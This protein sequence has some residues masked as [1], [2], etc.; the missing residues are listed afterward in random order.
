MP[1]FVLLHHECPLD[2]DK[3]SHWDF[4]VEAEGVL[5]TWELRELPTPWLDALGELRSAP[6]QQVYATR[7]ADHRMAFLDYEGPLTHNRGL[8]SCVTRGEYEFIENSPDRLEIR[9]GQPLACVI[10]LAA[11]SSMS[12]W[13]LIVRE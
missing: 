4:M 10:T 3:P 6:N 9:L 2:F 11:S 5:W 13:Q 1:R 12:R 7:L 8:V